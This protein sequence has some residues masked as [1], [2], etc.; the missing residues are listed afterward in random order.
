MA[1]LKGF[2]IE[3]FRVFGEPTWFDFAPITLLI[4]PNSS[5]KS[6]LLK[7]LQLLQNSE[8]AII[9]NRYKN[10]LSFANESLNLFSEKNFLNNPDS[11]F[12][13]Y[14]FLLPS[15]LF[16]HKLYLKISFDFVNSGSVLNNGLQLF[17]FD[18][19]DKSLK[20]LLI[21]GVPEDDIFFD[22][23]LF[24]KMLQPYHEV[25]SFRMV[26]SK[27]VAARKYF[28]E[29]DFKLY[30]TQIKEFEKKIRLSVNLQLFS[31]LEPS[32]GEA[33]KDIDAEYKN[34]SDQELSGLE[35]S[36]LI[37]KNVDAA[38]VAMDLV[39]VDLGET[40]LKKLLLYNGLPQEIA[41]HVFQ[42]IGVNRI[43]EELS[44][45]LNRFKYLPSIK[46]HQK[47]A[48]QANDTDQMNN[49]IKSI[50]EYDDENSFLRKW[51][52]EFKLQ[53]KIKWGSDDKLGVNYIELN[54]KSLLDYGFGISQIAAIL[55]TLDSYKKYHRPKSADINSAE[56]A[57][58]L[59]ESDFIEKNE[60]LLKS[61]GSISYN[62]LPI[63]LLEEPEANLHPAFQSKLADLFA[64][65]AIDYGQQLIVET[66]SEYMVRKFQYLVA[67]GKMK[68]E[69]VVIYYFHDPNN[70]PKG[71]KQVKRIDIL[72]D[73]SLS[74]DFGTGFFDEAAN[75]ELELLRLKNNKA[76]QN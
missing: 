26:N 59:S 7:S 11:Q 43:S 63:M 62:Q 50:G 57:I 39:D 69:D 19:R 24:F 22:I 38:L 5:G 1:H 4:G 28:E 54:E 49:I 3:N 42:L 30:E 32:S 33:I 51:E 76:R 75:W 31:E 18:S 37:D 53:G 40:R 47:R 15:K 25:D 56:K 34:L 6:S 48:Y 74:D 27:N 72:E 23:S 71:E 29:F 10:K 2:G 14:Y 60:H 41:I 52:E 70:V 55:L 58:T 65:V 35:F 17:F 45:I 46:G 16:K 67:K 73:G 8:I 61:P 21:N 68:K 9:N 20:P 12:V 13:N 66:H 44:I 36:E 64:E